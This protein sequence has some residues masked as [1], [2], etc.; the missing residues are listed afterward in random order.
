MNADILACYENLM[1]EI[2]AQAARD[3]TSHRPQSTVYEHWGQK[4]CPM[5]AFGFLIRTLGK[6]HRITRRVRTMRLLGE[7][8]AP[9]VTLG[10]AQRR[11]ND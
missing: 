1:H 3:A 2:F 5:E 6:D 7:T 9:Q 11:R 10:S 4:P 8:L